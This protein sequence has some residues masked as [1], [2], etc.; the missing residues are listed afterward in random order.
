MKDADAPVVACDVP[1]G[2]ERANGEVAGDAVRAGRTGTFHGSKI[3]LQVAPGTFHSGSCGGSRWGFPRGGAGASTAGTHLGPRPRLIRPSA[4][5]SKVTR[6]S[7]AV[8]AERGASR[9]GPGGAGP[10]SRPAPATCRFGSRG[11][12]GRARAAVLERCRRGAGRGRR[13]RAGRRVGG[14]AD[15]RAATEGGEIGPGHRQDRG[16][17]GVRRGVGGAVE[18]PL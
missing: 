2:V 3:G 9:C 10:A 6:E 17:E 13:A 8:A 16:A 1:S 14:T 18:R 12:R 7:C 4:R 15:G 5:G 11:G